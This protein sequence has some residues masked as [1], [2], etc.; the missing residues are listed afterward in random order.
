[1]CA[2]LGIDTRLVITALEDEG[3]VTAD[4]IRSL[5][6][7]PVVAPS[8]VEGSKLRV[9]WLTL[10]FHPRDQAELVELALQW[11]SPT[12]SDLYDICCSAGGVTICHQPTGERR[13]LLSISG[14]A[15]AAIVGTHGTANP[16]LAV[17]RAV[18]RNALHPLQVSRID[19]AVD[20]RLA[21]RNVQ[22]LPPKGQCFGF[23]RDGSGVQTIYYGPQGMPR[24]YRIYD[25][26]AK[27][28]WS[29]ADGPCT[30]FERELH[31]RNLEI[32]QIAALANPY[33]DLRLA[34]LRS[35]G[36]PFEQ[37]LLIEYARVVGLVALQ[38]ALAPKALRRVLA[39]LAKRQDAPTFPHPKDL[40]AAC[41]PSLA[42]RLL[43]R[44]CRKVRP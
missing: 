17:V 41:W 8:N 38:R 6:Q 30:R 22:P 33:S 23:F 7:H 21:F 40:Y 31:P 20:I 11:A 12:A 13:S 44:L 15:L 32:H 24:R 43:R 42:R 14:S 3:E 34:I 36:L 35:D 19:V 29:S 18:V 39:G 25:R 2:A 27:E 37:S 26:A 16:R 4:L 1:M 9:D 5:I 10:L 28:G